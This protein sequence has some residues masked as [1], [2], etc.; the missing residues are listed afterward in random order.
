MGWVLL[1]AALGIAVGLI[2]ITLGYKRSL[3]ILLATLLIGVVFIIWYAEYYEEK[4]SGLVDVGEVALENFSVRKTYG[5]SYEMSARVRNM[6][7]EYMLTAV[8]MELNASDCKTDTEGESCIIVGQ[9]EQEIQVDVP[10]QQA[11][12]IVQQFNFPAMRPVGSLRWSH[13]LLYTRG[14]E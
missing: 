1:V 7:T 3:F 4:G 10:P 14:R 9:Q 11:R 6:S 5:D 13:V 2:I 12:D 8:G